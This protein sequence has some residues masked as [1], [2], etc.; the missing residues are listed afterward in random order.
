MPQIFLFK[1]STIL[2]AGNFKCFI[3]EVHNLLT[4][5]KINEQTFFCINYNLNMH[6]STQISE[7]IKIN[8]M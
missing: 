8:Q 4:I 6:H 1:A 7:E 2:N 3:K 5:K